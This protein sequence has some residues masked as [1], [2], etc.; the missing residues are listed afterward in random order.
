MLNYNQI[1]FIVLLLG[2]GLSLGFIVSAAPSVIF[3]PSIYPIA[4]ST[5]SL[6][7]TTRQWL[8][9]YVQN[10]SS[11][12]FSI[13]STGYFNLNA[14]GTMQGGNLCTSINGVCG[15][16][17]GT[18]TSVAMTVPT[19][20]SISGSPITTSGTLGLTLTAGYNFL[21]NNASTTLD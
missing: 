18:V 21:T 12:A 1:K 8:N 20:L 6:G 4:T 3:Q 17:S 13:P 7:S 11:T 5:D 16:G 14:T 10:A 19:G 15:G 2:I 9:L